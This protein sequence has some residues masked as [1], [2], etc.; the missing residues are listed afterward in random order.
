MGADAK[1]GQQDLA[2]RWVYGPI[3]TEPEG[4]LLQGDIFRG[5]PVFGLATPEIFIVRDGE[6][7][8][9]SEVADAWARKK[10]DGSETLICTAELCNIIVLTQS[11]DLSNV[12]RQYIVYCPVFPAEEVDY[13]KKKEDSRRE[14]I[15]RNPASATA[16]VCYLPGCPDAAFDESFVDLTR[17]ATIMKHAN[18]KRIVATFTDAGATRILRLNPPYREF[19]S[20]R[21]ADLYGRIG[22]PTPLSDPPYH[23]LPRVGLEKE[24][25]LGC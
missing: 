3:G 14:A 23:G 24:N 19:L 9:P 11:C 1:P 16:N 17:V 13:W 22:L 25:G 2:H 15:R 8:A 21:F 18:A 6:V 4:D 7:K 5:F 12:E 20:R 10:Y